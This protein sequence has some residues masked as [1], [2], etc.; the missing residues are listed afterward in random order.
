VNE[1][2]AERA[3]LGL[4]EAYGIE[5]EYMIVDAGT[6]DVLPVTDRVMHAMAGG[7][8]DE[9][10]AGAL[11]WS[12]ELALHVIELKTNG[13]AP[14]LDGLHGSFQADIARINALLRESGGRLMPTAMHPWMDP[15]RETR[16]WPHDHSP[17]YEAFNRIF[18]CRGHG[19]SNLQSMHIN[20]PFRGDGE[21]ARL[22]A[23]IRATLPLLPALA[24]SSPLMDG[25]LT[26]TLDNRLEVYRTNARRIPSVSGMVVPEPVYSRAEYEKDLLGRIYHDLAL[27]DPE[28]ILRNEWV[29]ARGAIARF[30]RDAIEIRVLDTQE[31]PA[32]DLAFAR[33]IVAVVQALTEEAWYG[34]RQLRE[35]DTTT[36]LHS[37]ELCVRDADEAVIIDRTL[38]RIFGFPERGRC[39]ARELWQHLQETLLPHPPAEDAAIYRLYLNQG[40]LARRIV[41]A[42]EQE[43]GS[44]PESPDRTTLHQIYGRLCDCL[45]R[46]EPFIP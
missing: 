9:V 45:E 15:A 11:C 18:D 1:G 12:N 29:N 36:L 31:C 21:F 43:S 32:A 25:R 37:F 20:L 16:L 26:G 22:H 10:E 40:T 30:D 14:V 39:L 2:H 41:R 24:A 35:L 13:P 5:I 17:V 4:F 27:H 6:L 19:W 34:M 44:R 3:E 33:L 8:V 23:A 42:L 7:Y 38:P 28:G 46:G